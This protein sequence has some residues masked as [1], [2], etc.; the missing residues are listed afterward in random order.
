MRAWRR[1]LLRIKHHLAD[2]HFLRD[3][4]RHA[5]CVVQIGASHENQQFPTLLLP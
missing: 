1:R 5:L 4:K 2:V 3:E